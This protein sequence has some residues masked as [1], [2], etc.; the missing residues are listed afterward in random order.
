MCHP[1]HSLHSARF[2]ISEQMYFRAPVPRAPS[3]RLPS[4]E[5]LPLC[6][7]LLV[8]SQP[9]ASSNLPWSFLLR[10]PPNPSRKPLAQ[11]VLKRQ[12]QAQLRMLLDQPKL[13]PHCCIR[14]R[15][16]LQ[17]KTLLPRLP[18]SSVK[19]SPE[20]LLQLLHKMLEPLIDR[21]NLGHGV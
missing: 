20:T 4:T 14:Y 5:V 10:A 2:R 18:S 21:Y 12:L 15:L 7:P 8:P 11:P 17:L 1:R 9:Y 19:I 16:R 13:H 6:I 3:L